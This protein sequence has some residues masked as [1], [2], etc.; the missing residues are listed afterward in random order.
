M[1][2]IEQVNFCQVF[3]IEHYVDKFH[4]ISIDWKSNTC[5]I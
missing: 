2:C 3:Y 4:G 1:R 5:R